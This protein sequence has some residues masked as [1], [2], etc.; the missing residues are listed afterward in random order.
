MNLGSHPKGEWAVVVARKCLIDRRMPNTHNEMLE[1][2]RT[3]CS[4]LFGIQADF[5]SYKA[6][7]HEMLDAKDKQIERLREESSKAQRRVS[8]AEGPRMSHQDRQHD[9]VRAH[10]QAEARSS[11]TRGCD[12]KPRTARWDGERLCSEGK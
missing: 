4:R 10:K 2:I 7:T 11:I 6:M 12:T 8:Q 9:Q 1:D 5:D 3:E